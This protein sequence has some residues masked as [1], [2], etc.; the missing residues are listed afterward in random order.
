ML[1]YKWEVAGS[2]LLVTQAISACPCNPIIIIIMCDM[3]LDLE[4]F[5]CS[6][7]FVVNLVKVVGCELLSLG[8]IKSILVD[9]F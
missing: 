6:R 9:Y 2:I 8:Q 4:M 3:W 5:W 7:G 1:S